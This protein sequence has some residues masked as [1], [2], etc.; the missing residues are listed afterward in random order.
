MR[1][2]K[3]KCD[4]HGT[5]CR[6]QRAESREQRAVGKWFRIDFNYM[7]ICMLTSKNPV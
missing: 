4:E 5:R 1:K 3:T 2:R 7:F 6:E